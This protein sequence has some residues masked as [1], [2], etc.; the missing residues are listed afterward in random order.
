MAELKQYPVDVPGVP[1]EYT[2]Q[3]DDADARALGHIK[4]TNAPADDEDDEDDEKAAPAPA[5]KGGRR[6]ANKTAAK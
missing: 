3:L 5:N 6:P 2:V 4:D 1:A